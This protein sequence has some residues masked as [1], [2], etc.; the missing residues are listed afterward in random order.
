MS[1]EAPAFSAKVS[2]LDASGEK[3]AFAITVRTDYIGNETGIPYKVW[4]A[5]SID[6]PS[7]TINDIVITLLGGTPDPDEVKARRDR[8]RA[9]AARA[10]QQKRD[11]A[12]AAVRNA[13]LAKLPSVNSVSTSVFLGSDRKCAE[14]FQQ[15]LS[16]EGLEKRKRIADLIGYGCGFLADSPVRAETIRREGDYIFVKLVDGKRQGQ[17]GWI[18]SSWLWQAVNEA[19]RTWHPSGGNAYTPGAAC[20]DLRRE[21]HSSTMYTLMRLVKIQAFDSRQASAPSFARQKSD[22]TQPPNEWHLVAGQLR[23]FARPLRVKT[24]VLFVSQGINRV[25]VRSFHRRI[26]SEDH[27]YRHRHTER[28]HDRGRGHDGL[29]FRRP[30][31]QPRQEEAEP[32]PQ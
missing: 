4:G 31:D 15:A 2:G 28:D 16:M 14:E 3:R 9:L 32:D 12:A 30:G 19:D 22:P 26:D 5:C 7:L 25:D 20:L 17:S 13:E 6:A 11:A 10:A 21:S 18:P 29:P 24:A 27:T 8:A 1:W 23:I